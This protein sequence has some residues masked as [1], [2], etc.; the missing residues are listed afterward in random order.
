MATMEQ[1]EKKAAEYNVARGALVVLVNSLHNEVEAAKKKYLRSIRDQVAKTKSAESVLHV[2][3]EQNPELF[4]RPKSLVLHGIG[5]GWRKQKGKIKFDAKKIV[6]MIEKHLP[7]IA[8]LLIKTTKRPV[9][10]AI[11]KLPVD[12]LKK[13]GATVTN[14]GDVAFVEPVDGEVDK[15]VTALLSVGK[16]IDE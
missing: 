5:L 12:D 10:A 3:V 7:S 2:M 15:I 11:G 6:S 13:I 1:I 8:E 4:V 16:E 9:K 14:T